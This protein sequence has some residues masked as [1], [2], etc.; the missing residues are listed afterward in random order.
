MAAGFELTC[1]RGVEEMKALIVLLLWGVVAAAQNPPPAQPEANPVHD[2][3]SAMRVDQGCVNQGNDRREFAPVVC[4]LQR[5]M[6]WKSKHE[7]YFVL[8]GK[9]QGSNLGLAWPPYAVFNL[10]NGNGRWRMFRIGFRYDRNWR[11]YIFPTVAAKY[12]S[13]PLRY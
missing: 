12:V 3:P 6:S 8:I 7:P 1:C 10:S 13:H 5:G 11:G 4:W 9:P 2:Q